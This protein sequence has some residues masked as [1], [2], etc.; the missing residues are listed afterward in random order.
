MGDFRSIAYRDGLITSTL[1]KRF[2]DGWRCV[3]CD[4]NI[5]EEILTTK[6]RESDNLSLL[7]APLKRHFMENHLEEYTAICLFQDY[8]ST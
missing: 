4:K 8:E 7:D 6:T 1:I 5:L 2:L 3:L